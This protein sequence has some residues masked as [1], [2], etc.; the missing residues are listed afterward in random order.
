MLALQQVAYLLLIPRFGMA[1]ALVG[2]ALPQALAGLFTL[3]LLRRRQEFGW[4]AR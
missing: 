4:L 1:G 2:F 3:A